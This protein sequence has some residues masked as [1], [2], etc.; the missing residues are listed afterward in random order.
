[1][2]S[3]SVAIHSALGAGTKIRCTAVGHAFIIDQP[4]SAGGED[5]GPTPLEYYLA[6]VA[7]CVLSIARIVARQ[8]KIELRKME[9]DAAGKIDTDVLMGSN[10]SGRAGFESIGLNVRIDAEL[11]DAQKEEFLEE[12]MRRCPVSENTKNPTKITTTIVS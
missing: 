9:I 3:K 5:A 1:M 6:S 4:K 12:V 8:K 11:S 2:P 10:T 7:G